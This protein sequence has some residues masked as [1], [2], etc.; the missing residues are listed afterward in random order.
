[1][2]FLVKPTEGHTSAI[3]GKVKSEGM[4]V[5]RKPSQTRVRPTI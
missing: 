5:R 4:K 2:E 1:M 3:P